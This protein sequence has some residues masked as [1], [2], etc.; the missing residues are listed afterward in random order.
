MWKVGFGS[1]KRDGNRLFLFLAGARAALVLLC[2]CPIA[3]LEENG[4]GSRT[5][6]A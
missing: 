3:A 4:A 2:C 5:L 6:L 1:L